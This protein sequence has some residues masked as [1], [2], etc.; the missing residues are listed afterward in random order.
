MTQTASVGLRERKKHRTTLALQDAAYRL[1]AEKGYRQTTVDDIAAA[2]GVSTRTYYRYYKN[3]EDVVLRPLGDSLEHYRE[4]L[5]GR[6][7]S[8]PAMQALQESFMEF[9]SEVEDPVMRKRLELVAKEPEL[10]RGAFALG[11]QW[12]NKITSDLV[13]KA[14]AGQTD[15]RNLWLAAGMGITLW[16]GSLRLWVESGSKRALTD[17]V[18]DTFGSIAE[19]VKSGLGLG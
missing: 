7:S 5:A 12:Q 6:P 19:V 8:E 15:R 3:K 17:I 14:P 16:I 2:A 18:A 4:I 9:T 11:T 10:Q 13:V 1:F